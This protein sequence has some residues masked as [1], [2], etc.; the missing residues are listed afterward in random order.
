MGS[1]VKFIC[2]ALL[3][4]ATYSW[5]V[6]GAVFKAGLSASIILLAG[7]GI[8]IDAILDNVLKKRPRGIKFNWKRVNYY[9]P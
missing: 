2:T 4:Y 1:F 9:K 8:V 6:S 7:A 5:Y 3:L